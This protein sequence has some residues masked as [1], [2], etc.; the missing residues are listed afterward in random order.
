MRS[1]SFGSCKNVIIPFSTL[2]IFVNQLKS[3]SLISW[4][5]VARFLRVIFVGVIAVT[6][7]LSGFNG[8]LRSSFSS[9]C[10][11]KRDA[12]SMLLM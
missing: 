2:S 11:L 3:S 5:T 1:P 6:W 9:G 10:F 12:K 8:V 4:P 7:S